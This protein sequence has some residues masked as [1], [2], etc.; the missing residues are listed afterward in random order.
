MKNCR[1]TRALNKKEEEEESSTSQFGS[2]KAQKK[3]RTARMARAVCDSGKTPPAPS[4]RR[5]LRSPDLPLGPGSGQG[6][7]RSSSSEDPS[8]LLRPVLPRR[9]WEEA[10]ILSGGKF[11]R[12]QSP[13]ALAMRSSGLRVSGHPL[14]RLEFNN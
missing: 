11:R 12:D 2:R 8:L 13:L 14:F 1:E 7:P 6:L 3:Q 4:P 10:G 5:Y 9:R